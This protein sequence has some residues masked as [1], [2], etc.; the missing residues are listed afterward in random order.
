VINLLILVQ[1]ETLRLWAPT[2]NKGRWCVADEPQTLRV[3][4]KDILVEPDTFVTINLYGCQSNPK[5]WGPDAAE[6]KPSR[7]IATDPKT[8]IEA[9]GQPPP[10]A[11]YMPWAAGPRICPGKKFSQVEFVAVIAM[12]LHGYRLKPLKMGSQSEPEA[13]K[14]LIAVLEDSKNVIT[15]KMRR[16]KE[17]GIVLEA[18]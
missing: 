17:A 16:P 3:G 5:Y 13:G 4:D 14:S 12:L 2:P 10:K 18:R 11:A 1:Y 15:P 6:W 9:I 8:G 7:W